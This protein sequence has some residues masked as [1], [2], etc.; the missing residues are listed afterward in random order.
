MGAMRKT[1]S[2]ELIPSDENILEDSPITK[3]QADRELKLNKSGA[4]LEAA[5]KAAAEALQA[6]KVTYDRYGD[7]VA[8]EVDHATRLRGSEL[9]GKYWG[10]LKESEVKVGVGVSVGPMSKEEKEL[11]DTYRSSVVSAK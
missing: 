1:T 3:K 5:F 2:Q 6:E 11:I 10:I 8:R 9:I 7:E 4:T